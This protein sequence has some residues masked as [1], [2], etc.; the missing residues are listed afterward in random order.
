L[1][2]QIKP[3]DRFSPIEFAVVIGVAF[4]ASIF[5]SFDDLLTGNTLGEGTSQSTFG[6][7]DTYY[8]LAYD[9]MVAPLLV[10]ILHV[11]GWR[12]KDFR[13]RFSWK[14]TAVALVVAVGMVLGNHVLDFVMKVLS[15]DLQS[16]IEAWERYYPTDPPSLLATV[17]ISL[18]NPVFEE[19]FVCGYVVKALHRRFGLTTAICVSVAIR[20][21]YHLYQ[22][23]AALPFHLTY[24]LVQALVYVRCGRLWPLILSHVLLDFAA[25]WTFIAW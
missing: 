16:A 18:V 14:T 23:L 20:V 19:V 8:A 21:A 25:M 7:A 4:G 12:L 1:G 11:G 3:R 24:G 10:W 22:G 13:L 2:E 15:P 5:Y 17:A 9:L 6:E